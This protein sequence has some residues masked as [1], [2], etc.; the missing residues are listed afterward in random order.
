MRNNKAKAF[1]ELERREKRKIIETYEIVLQS[2]NK[3]KQ[4]RFNVLPDG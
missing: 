2:S 1:F 4:E 3:G